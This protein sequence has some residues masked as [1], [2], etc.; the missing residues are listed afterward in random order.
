M[1]GNRRDCLRGDV[2]DIEECGRLI[3]SLLVFKDSLREKL[4]S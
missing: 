1:A 2:R 3:L 4:N